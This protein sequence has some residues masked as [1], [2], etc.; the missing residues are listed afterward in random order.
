[1]VTGMH[2]AYGNPNKNVEAIVGQFQINY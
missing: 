1:M 2:V